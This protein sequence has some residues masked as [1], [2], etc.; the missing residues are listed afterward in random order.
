V[1][2]KHLPS[3]TGKLM[4]RFTVISNEIPRLPET[5]GALAGRMV[6]LRMTRSFYGQED[7]ALMARFEPEWPGILLWAIEG[8]RRLRDRG[9]FVQP[10]SGKPLVEE[11][12][13]LSSP[14]G[15][16][17]KE[18]CVIGPEHQCVVGDLFAKWK[19]WCESKNRPQ[20]GDESSFGR[21]LRSI[22]PDLETRP[23]KQAGRY[24]RVFE[25]I[26]IASDLADF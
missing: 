16:F 3:W 23:A 13:D 2:R 17:I 20:V 26:D 10:A 21:N 15:M 11:M 6:I 4:A 7:R 19:G 25:G 22:L 1:D 9:H 8:W 5:S 12:E 24:F 14:V 18:C